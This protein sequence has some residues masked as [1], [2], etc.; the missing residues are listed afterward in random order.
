MRKLV[1]FFPLIFTLVAA[2]SHAWDVDL[3]IGNK[4]LN[5]SDWAPLEEQNE[6]SLI[7][8][9]NPLMR[10]ARQPLSLTY[11]VSWAGDAKNNYWLED[12]FGNSEK[13][14]M[15]ASLFSLKLG[16]KRLWNPWKVVKLSA[17]A[18]G[19]V[20]RGTVEGYTAYGSAKQTGVG[21]GPWGGLNAWFDFG[22]VNMGG[23]CEYSFINLNFEGEDNDVNAG[24]VH[25]GFFGGGNW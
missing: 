8:D 9:T 7:I 12:E 23:Y 3:K 10:I 13:V 17:I 5:K 24:G 16:V 4:I 21:G 22:H 1:L 19:F 18:G 25:F 11:G 20:A 14:S 15:G 6:V 2:S